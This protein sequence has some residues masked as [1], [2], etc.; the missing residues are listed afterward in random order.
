MN[1]NWKK[2]VEVVCETLAV[3]F[4]YWVLFFNKATFK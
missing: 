2:V 1:I 4:L 3:C